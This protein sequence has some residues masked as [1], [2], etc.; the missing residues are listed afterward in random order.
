[1][2]GRIAPRS[3][4]TLRRFLRFLFFVL[5]AIEPRYTHAD[6]FVSAR[7][8]LIDS[9]VARPFFTPQ[10]AN[11]SANEKIAPVE[12]APAE[13]TPPAAPSPQI[14]PPD[15]EDKFESPREAEPSKPT[16]RRNVVVDNQT[17]VHT[18]IDV[19]KK[20]RINVEEKERILDFFKQ[21]IT[22]AEGAQRHNEL[23]ENKS[24]PIT[25]NTLPR[26]SRLKDIVRARLRGEP[27]PDE[28][29]TLPALPICASN[30]IRRIDTNST[31]N[32]STAYDYIFYSR[33]DLAQT[34][35]AEAVVPPAKVI[36][37]QG[38]VAQTADPDSIA[39]QSLAGRLEIECLPT[40]FRMLNENGTRVLEYRRG[41][42]AWDS[43]Q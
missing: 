28:A 6:D 12:P 26:R 40:R 8:A 15:P 23:I 16:E 17:A 34:Q 25:T 4:G 32:S 20:A 36:A 27:A 2:L 33:G 24:S 41:T 22:D 14:L 10:T 7:G 3:I 39:N 30:D 18:S 29:V 1:M 13:Q 35:R 5:V 43:A 21:A 37:Y 31:T 11:K 9:D 38:G 19:I 42:A